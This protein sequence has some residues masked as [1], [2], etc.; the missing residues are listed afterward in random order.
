MIS[1]AT[2]PAKRVRS[3]THLGHSAPTALVQAEQMK[4]G[5]E[6]AIAQIKQILSE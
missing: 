6:I 1:R 3:L 2:S 5:T 4:Q